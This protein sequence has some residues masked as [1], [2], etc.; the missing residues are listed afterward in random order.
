[1][2]D[3]LTDNKIAWVITGLDQLEKESP[4]NT[5]DERNAKAHIRYAIRHLH[6]CFFYLTGEDKY[7]VVHNTPYAVEGDPVNGNYPETD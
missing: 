2:S 6:K 1:M 5:E 4:G 3:P 7:G